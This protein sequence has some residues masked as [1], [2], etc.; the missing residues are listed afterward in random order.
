VLQN[1][2]PRLYALAWPEASGEIEIARSIASVYAPGD[3][4]L[5]HNIFGVE[6]G[7]Q[8]FEEERTASAVWNDGD[9]CSVLADVLE[10]RLV[11][12]LA[13]ERIAGGKASGGNAAVP[14]LLAAK[15]CE[16]RLVND[17]VCGAIDFDAVVTAIPAL[18]LMASRKETSCGGGGTS[19]AW[20]PE[21]LLQA[22]FRPLFLPEGMQFE[23]AKLVPSAK[24]A[25][26]VL[27]AIRASR[28]EEAVALAEQSYRAAN[29]QIIRPP[30]IE[31]DGDRIA[32]S[33]LIPMSEAE[34][35]RGFNRWIERVEAND[36]RENNA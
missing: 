1:L 22:L 6:P 10:R 25:R 13:V 9:P 26:A 31:A 29:L 17:F 21:F 4:R 7:G 33:L 3:Y 19:D 28:W 2:D 30:A 35:R 36:G 14:P 8:R 27:R 15:Y 20:S 11:D 24:R 16:P 18:S 5:F 12:V 34:A 23:G 32:A